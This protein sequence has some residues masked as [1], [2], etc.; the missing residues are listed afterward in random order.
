MQN[1]H[2]LWVQFFHPSKVLIERI[3]NPAL[4]GFPFGHKICFCH[5]GIRESSPDQRACLLLSGTHVFWHREAADLAI[6]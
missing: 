2:R 1:T 4:T 6:A 5:A 3:K